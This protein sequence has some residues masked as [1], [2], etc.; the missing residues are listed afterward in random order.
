MIRNIIKIFNFFT[1]SW[2]IFVCTRYAW[3]TCWRRGT[4]FARTDT[5]CTIS[6]LALY[7]VEALEEKYKLLDKL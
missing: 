7:L 6:T 3:L 4:S 5:T 1:L 2:G